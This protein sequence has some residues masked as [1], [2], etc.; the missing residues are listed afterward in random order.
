MFCSNCGAKI[1][2]DELYCSECGAYQDVICTPKRNLKTKVASF[3]GAQY[4]MYAN[5]VALAT[6]PIMFL[7]RILFQKKE[8]LWIGEGDAWSNVDVLVVP[9]LVKVVLM[10]I[11]AVSLM[12]IFFLL[13]SSSTPND[14]KA[15]ETKSIS[16][17]NIVFGLLLTFFE[18]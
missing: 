17:I 16:L 11:L 12:L 7:L 15:K 1:G 18:F 14:R 6:L 8:T 10:L 4:T 5:Y 3:N 2:K 13:K 9:H